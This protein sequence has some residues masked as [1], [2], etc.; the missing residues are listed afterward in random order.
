MVRRMTL[1]FE[2]STKNVC[3]KDGPKWE[4]LLRKG[5]CSSS[6]ELIHQQKCPH[7]TDQD[8][9]TQRTQVTYPRTHR[10][11]S[12]NSNPNSLTLELLLLITKLSR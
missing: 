8:A 5:S 7:F 10:D 9:E 3:Y 11:Y 2:L 4:G 1:G 12:R 6:Q